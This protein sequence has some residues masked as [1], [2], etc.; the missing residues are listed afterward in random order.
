[1][2]K[3]DRTISLKKTTKRES[4]NFAIELVV[5]SETKGDNWKFIYKYVIYDVKRKMVSI[6]VRI[7]ELFGRKYARKSIATILIIN[8]S[9]ILA[10]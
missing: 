6:I 7:L 10:N 1:M 5:V 4:M 3:H 9:I 2:L 8:Y